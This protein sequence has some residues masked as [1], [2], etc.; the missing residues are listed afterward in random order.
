MGVRQGFGGFQLG[1]QLGVLL[2]QPNGIAGPGGEGF[3]C[4]GGGFGGVFPPHPYFSIHA[5]V[6]AGFSGRLSPHLGQD[7]VVKHTSGDGFPVG[8]AFLCGGWGEGASPAA[9][10]G[11]SGKK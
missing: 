10:R 5:A 11:S 6:S 3:C 8:M 9:R 1:S 4:C 7:E 2:S